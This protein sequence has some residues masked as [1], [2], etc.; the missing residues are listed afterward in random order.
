MAPVFEHCWT[1]TNPKFGVIGGTAE[2][3]WIADLNVVET[4]A[5]YCEYPTQILSR[6]KPEK[7]KQ[8]S[9]GSVKPSIR[10]S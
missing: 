8:A 1:F 10:N 7:R 9:P 4:N 3:E 6:I 2:D 5:S